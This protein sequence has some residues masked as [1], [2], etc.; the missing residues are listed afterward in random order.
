MNWI[1]PGKFLSFSS[2]SEEE[3]DEEGYR[4][5]TPENYSKIFES[6]GIGSIMQ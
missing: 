2:P 4:T 3:H 5:Y 1:V 6:E